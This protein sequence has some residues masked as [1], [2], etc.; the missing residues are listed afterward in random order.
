MRK[1]SI[2][3]LSLALPLLATSCVREDAQAATSAPAKAALPAQ[4]AK[5]PAAP[6]MSA[7]E[8]AAALPGYPMEGMPTFLRDG[9]I[10]AS[11]DEFVFDGSPY[12]LAGC[13]KQNYS[14]K[15]NAIRGLNLLAT[16]MNAGASRSEALTSYS[17]YYRS[18]D[19]AQRQTIDT[20]G[21]ACRGPA[22]AKVK[23]VEFSD[24]ECPHCAAA[25]PLLEQLVA[26]HRDVQLC[27]MHF[28]L[29]MHTNASSA[30]QATS[31][32]QRHGKFWELHDKIF[33]NQQRLSPALIKQL[34]QEVGLDPKALVRAVEADELSPIVDKQ[35]AEGVRLGIQGT[36][37]IYMN[38]RKLELPL[39]PALLRFTIEDELRWT[40]NGGKWTAP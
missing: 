24:F 13:I 3:L 20:A 34:V 36:P 23:I 38:G 21:A 16:M 5:A 32:A 2:S 22:D 10:A 1:L 33:E 26:Q 14:C 30:A 25:R 27:F 18:F 29:P 28:P 31:F 4:E 17:R 7:E 39:M 9:I 12:T 8:A 37:S 11:Q 35:K 15:E 6:S 19:P 40:A